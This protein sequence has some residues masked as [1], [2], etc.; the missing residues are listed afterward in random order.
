MIGTYRT[1]ELHRRHPLRPWLSEMERLPRVRRFELSPFGGAELGSQVEAISGIAPETELIQAIERRAEGNP[2]FIE[3]LLAARGEGGGAAR[4]PETL[5]D[6]LLSRVATLSED[7]QRVMGMAAVDGRSVE[8]GLLAEVAGRPEVNLEDPLREALAAQLLVND[9]RRAAVPIGSVTRS[10][11]R[12]STTTSSRRNGV[13]CTPHTRRR[14]KPTRSP[15]ERKGRACSPR[16]PITRRPPM[17]RSGR[18]GRGSQPRGRRPRRTR[19]P[20]ASALSSVR[21]SSGTRSRRMIA[22][23]AWT[24]SC[25]TTR[26]VWRR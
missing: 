11:P 16:L 23:A 10:S 26:Q 4:L 6:V 14:S 8:P 20:R 18:C 22:R 13:A 7:A 21:S 2:F 24:W 5:R 17:N 12:R 19:S 9:P 25:C 15:R 3:E 1:D